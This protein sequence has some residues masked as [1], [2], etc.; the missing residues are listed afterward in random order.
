MKKI[1][2]SI[3]VP[4]ERLKADFGYTGYKQNRNRSV[5]R[6]SLNFIKQLL[7]VREKNVNAG[8]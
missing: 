5:N 1:S 7:I 3:S 6:E 4:I 8:D 2:K